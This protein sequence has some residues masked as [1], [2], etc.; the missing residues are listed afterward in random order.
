MIVQG[1][2]CPCHK[3]ANTTLGLLGCNSKSA[4]PAVSEMYRIFFQLFPPSLLRNTPRSV[5]ATNGFP[6]AATYTRSGFAGCTRIVEI[7]PTSRN[8]IK[9]QVLPASI[10]L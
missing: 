10:D 7:W 3:Q 8:P 9:V 5:F 2:R 1:L 4:P 6:S